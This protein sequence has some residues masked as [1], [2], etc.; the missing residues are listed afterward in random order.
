[1]YKGLM[2]L[3]LTLLLNFAALART[4][5]TGTL[6]DQDGKPLPAADVEVQCPA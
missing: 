5:I 6:L 2:F 1:M 3:A 4:T